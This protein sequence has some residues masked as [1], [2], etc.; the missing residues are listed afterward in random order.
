MGSCVQCVYLY[1]KSAALLRGLYSGFRLSH[2]HR[3]MEDY[4]NE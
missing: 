4:M 3:R 2:L 1:G